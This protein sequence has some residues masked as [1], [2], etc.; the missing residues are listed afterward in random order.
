MSRLT[1]PLKPP[2]EKHFFIGWAPTP[3]YLKL[4]LVAVGIV[5]VLG[6]TGLA[7]LI[8]ATKPDP[9]PGQF[10]FG[11]GRQTL[12]GVLVAE[13]YPTLTVTVGSERVAAGETILLAG[14]GK[15]G[16]QAKA[17]PLDGSYVQAE[18]IMLNRGELQMMQAR[19][20]QNGL[21]AAETDEDIVAPV[22]TNLG[23]WR[24]TGE[25]CDGKCLSGAMRPG[26][27]LSHKA[28]ANLCLIGGAPPVLVTT[29]PV[30][31]SE[32][33][34]VGAPDGGPVSD[35]LYDL[36]GRLA[37]MEGQLKRRG[38]MLIFLTDLDQAS[39]AP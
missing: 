13:P 31:G 34:L 3:G 18:G 10:Q 5:L 33:M 37:T 38:N 35:R 4:F 30:E 12:E 27:G 29:E 26:T 8:A 11:W 14:P 22:E 9:G 19:G 20:G 2:G 39:V 32:F 7:T 25:I 16:V 6:F 1:D 23:R 21:K 17:T 28:C 15:R 24:L 36:T